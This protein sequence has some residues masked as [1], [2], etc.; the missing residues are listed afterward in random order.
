MLCWVFVFL[1][2][3]IVASLQGLGGVAATAAGIAQI[4]FFVFLIVFLIALVMGAVRHR[5]A[6]GTRSGDPEDGH[7]DTVGLTDSAIAGRKPRAAPADRG[8]HRHAV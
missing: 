2:T 7:E 1:G 8:R 4:L 6:A 5:P 3:A